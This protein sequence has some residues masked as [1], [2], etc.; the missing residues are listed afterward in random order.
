MKRLVVAE[1]NLGNNSS[2][3]AS[4]VTEILLHCSDQDCTNIFELCSTTDDEQ[5]CHDADLVSWGFVWKIPL[6]YGGKK[7]P[8]ICK[9]CW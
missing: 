3:F 7:I 1:F 5:D 4:P 8:A 2:G 9:Y 6:I